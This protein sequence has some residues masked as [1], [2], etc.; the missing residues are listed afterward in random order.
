MSMWQTCWDFANPIIM[1]GT[2]V[3]TI[4]EQGSKVVSLKCKASVTN[5]KSTQIN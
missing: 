5:C 4:V 1:N 2:T 3:W